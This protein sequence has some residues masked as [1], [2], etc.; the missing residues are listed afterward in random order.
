M[1]RHSDKPLDSND[2]GKLFVFALLSIPPTIFGVGIVPALFLLFGIFMLRKSG[3]FDHIETAARN[4]RLFCILSFF[5]LGSIAC[6]LVVK[7]FGLSS[8]RYSDNAALTALGWHSPKSVDKYDVKIEME[9]CKCDEQNM[10]WG[11]R[12]KQLGKSSI[13]ATRLLMWPG[14]LGFQRVSCTHG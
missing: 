13:E 12:T 8:D 2:A 6:Y 11:S 10:P 9:K 4:Y 1:T 3:D 14:G 7:N 5:G